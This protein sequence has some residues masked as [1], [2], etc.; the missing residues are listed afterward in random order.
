MKTSLSKNHYL[1]GATLSLAAVSVASTGCAKEEEAQ[2]KNVLL[3]MVD[4]LRP[5]LGVFGRDVVSPNIDA[6][7][8]SGVKFNKSYCNIPVSGASRASLLS[9]TRPTRNT[10]LSYKSKLEEEKPEAVGIN[11]HFQSLDY[12]TISRGK[13]FHYAPDKKEG[14]DER[15]GAG[16]EH[17]TSLD[18]ERL[19]AAQAKDKRCYIYE[20]VEAQDNEYPDGRIAEAAVADLERLA[21]SGEQFFLG[22][23]FFRPHLPFI[24]PKKY[25]DLYNFEDISVPENFRMKEGHNIPRQLF[26]TF[27]ELYSYDGLPENGVPFSEELA[28]R[29]IHGY[30]ACVSYT[31]AQV[32]KVMDKLRETGLDKNTVVVLIG[33]HGWNLGDHGIWAKHTMFDTATRTP[34]IIVD[35][36]AKLKGY[37]SEAVVEYVDLFPTICDIAGVSTPAQVEGESLKPLLNKRGAQHKGYAISRWGNGFSII[38]DEGYHY[39]EWWDKDDNVLESALFDHNVDPNEDHNIVDDPKYAEIVE[40]LSAQLMANRGAEFDKY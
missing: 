6:L 26:T 29:L 17:T 35:P 15:T 40:R 2:R 33:D 8:E 20:G 39:A 7:A 31:D 18:K 9:G 13:I 37:T 22:V 36:S 12:T 28:R 32:G 11:N 27:G 24:C 25:W 19:A 21:K 5:E 3:I 1:L 30:R 4:D 14:W 10:F 38:T 23:G 16:L 34:M